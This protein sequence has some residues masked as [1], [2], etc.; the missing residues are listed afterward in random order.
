MSDKDIDD[1]VVRIDQRGRH[2]G[3]AEPPFPQ[4][5]DVEWARSVWHA[6]RVE[7]Y[8][9]GAEHVGVIHRDADPSA[10]E[11]ASCGHMTGVET[12]QLAMGS[13]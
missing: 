9:C 11:C 3:R 1:V 4:V 12:E 13:E 7:C 6:A 5:V 2:V 8:T 10:L